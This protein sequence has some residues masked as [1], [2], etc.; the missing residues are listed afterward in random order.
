MKI[1]GHGI[2]ETGAVTQELVDYQSKKK[3]RERVVDNQGNV[4]LD[5]L[6]GNIKRF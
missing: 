4:R 5:Y 3:K 1:E 2:K 6:L